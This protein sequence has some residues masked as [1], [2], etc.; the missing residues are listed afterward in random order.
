M[1]IICHAF[2]RIVNQPENVA[3]IFAEYI[4]EKKVKAT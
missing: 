3:Q 2:N 1:I 4:A